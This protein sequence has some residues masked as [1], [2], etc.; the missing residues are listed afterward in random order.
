VRED[1]DALLFTPN[2]QSDLA[3]QVLRLLNDPQLADRL[4]ASAAERAIRRFT[5]HTS[6]KRLL[7]VYAAFE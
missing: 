3:R 5:W 7:D 6:Q 2:D 4:A 1:I